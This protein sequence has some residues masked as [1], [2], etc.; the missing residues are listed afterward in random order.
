M[1]LHGER[2]NALP[3]GRTEEDAG[4][5]HL[6]PRAPAAARDYPKEGDILGS[7]R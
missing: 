1:H 6:K 2:L 4:M 5:L 7:E 3:G